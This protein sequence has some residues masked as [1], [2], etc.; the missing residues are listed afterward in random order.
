MKNR[1]CRVPG[2]V[3]TLSAMAGHSDAAH[4]Y[5]TVGNAGAAG[6]VRYHEPQLEPRPD[7]LRARLSRRARRALPDQHGR[8]G[9][10]ANIHADHRAAISRRRR[11]VRPC[12]HGA[13]GR[14][15]LDHRPLCAQAG[16]RAAFWP[17]CGRYEG[18][19][20]F[21]RSPRYPICGSKPGPAPCTCSSPTTRRPPA[22]GHGG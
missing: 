2:A 20:R 6:I 9:H 15:G 22:T 10:K 14:T 11:P 8:G 3:G 5:S 21:R 17:R 12:G 18:I 1:G 13:G 7:R 16:G 4:R 19:C